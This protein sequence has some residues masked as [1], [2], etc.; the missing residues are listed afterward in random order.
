V[1]IY[2]GED[3]L[4]C[5]SFRLFAL[6]CC[7]RCGLRTIALLVMSRLVSCRRRNDSSRRD[8]GFAFLG[9]QLH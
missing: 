3:G 5:I 4:L 8:K 7:V 6:V 1:I 9:V 2:V